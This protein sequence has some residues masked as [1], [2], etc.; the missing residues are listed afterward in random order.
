MSA[1]AKPDLSRILASIARSTDRTALRIQRDNAARKGAKEVVDACER[2]LKQLRDG[3]YLGAFRAEL[4]ERVSREPGRRL[5]VWLP[6]AHDRH[7]N[8]RGRIA[9]EIRVDEE[10]RI[11]IEDM[12]RKTL[13]SSLSH[14]RGLYEDEGGGSDSWSRFVVASGKTI[15]EHLGVDPAEAHE[16]RRSSSR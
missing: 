8:P 5:R 10:F 12:A 4:V 15:A 11:S 6:L 9:A 7:G 1:T 3:D 16:S 13:H 14:L 2:R